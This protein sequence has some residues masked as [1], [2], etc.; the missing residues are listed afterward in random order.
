MSGLHQISEGIAVIFSRTLQDIV[1][2][3]KPVVLDLF[4]GSSKPGTLRGQLLQGRHSRLSH[5]CVGVLGCETRRVCKK[6]TSLWACLRRPGGCSQALAQGW[7]ASRL[8]VLQA[9]ANSTHKGRKGA[10]LFFNCRIQQGDTR[11]AILRTSM[12]ESVRR[13]ASK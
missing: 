13:L 4:Q 2:L 1:F 3:I 11:K 7:V 6:R 12:L 10:G 5:R 8:P 9:L